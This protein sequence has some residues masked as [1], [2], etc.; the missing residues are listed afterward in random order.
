MH[1][2]FSSCRVDRLSVV[3]LSIQNLSNAV[4]IDRY[5]THEIHR[6]LSSQARLRQ[7]LDGFVAWRQGHRGQQ[8]DPRLSTK[9]TTLKLTFLHLLPRPGGKLQRP[10]TRTNKSGTTRSGTCTQSAH[11]VP[12]ELAQSA[13]QGAHVGDTAHS[14]VTS[15]TAQVMRDQT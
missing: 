15:V 3:Q 7:Q 14:K 11:P 4:R 8:N 2:L 9:I 5:R 1:S 13:P 6:Y 10:T 12:S